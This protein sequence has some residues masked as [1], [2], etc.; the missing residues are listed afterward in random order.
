MT[1]GIETSRELWK[2]Q[3][4]HK[5]A[6]L[7]PTSHLTAPDSGV[8]LTMPVPSFRDDFTRS[9]DGAPLAA[10]DLY[11]SGLN[12]SSRRLIL[13]LHEWPFLFS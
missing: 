2:K 7:T 9:I 1:K 12:R 10:E 11:N 5:I 6:I 4:K 8:P 13:I 3:Y